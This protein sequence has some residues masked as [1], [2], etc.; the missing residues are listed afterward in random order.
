[1]TK[2]ICKKTKYQLIINKLLLWFININF[3]FV[4][5]ICTT[6]PGHMTTWAL[7]HTNQRS[8]FQVKIRLRLPCFIFPAMRKTVFTWMEFQ[9]MQLRGKLV[10][11]IYYNED[12]FRPYPGFQQIRLIR[13]STSTG[14]EYLL[15][16]VDF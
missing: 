3:W 14:R 2:N 1:M 16:F 4:L 5:K 13:K 12:I 7:T 9:M 8:R 6:H 11:I 15:C 10:V